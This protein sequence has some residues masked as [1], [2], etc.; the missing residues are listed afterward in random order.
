[1]SQR[2]LV[3]FDGSDPAS[4]ALEQHDNGEIVVLY[5]IDVS[6]DRYGIEGALSEELQSHAREVL[7]E[8]Q[9][10]ADRFE[11]TLATAIESGKPKHVVVAYAED[12]DIDRIVIGSHRRSGISRTLFGSIAES[13]MRR[14]S[15]S[16]TVAG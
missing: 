12:R 16:V 5:A 1:M 3:P 13:V 15:V 6:E 14:A 11:T 4:I 8:A 9:D 2:V 10:R 7:R